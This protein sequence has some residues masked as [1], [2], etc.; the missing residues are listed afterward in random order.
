MFQ[1]EFK[2]EGKMIKGQIIGNWS[3]N[4]QYALKMSELNST[5]LGENDLN[6]LIT[7][8]T[9]ISEQVKEL[10]DEYKDKFLY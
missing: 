3:K 8:L 5:T 2:V 9:K 4:S 10:N 1:K 7:E 6:T